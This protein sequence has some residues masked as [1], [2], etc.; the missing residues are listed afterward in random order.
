M[1]ASIALPIKVNYFYNVQVKTFKLKHKRIIKTMFVSILMCSIITIYFFVQ[2]FSM[3]NFNL[4]WTSNFNLCWTFGLFT[5]WYLEPSLL[6][7]GNLTL[8]VQGLS[9]S[10]RL[11]PHPVIVQVID[12]VQMFRPLLPTLLLA[13]RLHF[14]QSAHQSQ[15]VRLR[16]SWYVKWLSTFTLDTV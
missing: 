12:F 13:E 8:H 14:Y 1:I 5:Y 7:C 10:Q 11:P 15:I 3:S 6:Y 4:F 9:P 16:L 2:Y